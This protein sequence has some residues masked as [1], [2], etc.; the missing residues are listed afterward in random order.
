MVVVRIMIK[1]IEIVNF[2]SHKNTRLEFNEFTNVIIG[3]NDAGK[4]S[5]LRAINWVVNNRPIGIDVDIREGQ[6][7]VQVQLD[8]DHASI[9]RGKGKE[10]HYYK[11]QAGGKEEWFKAFGKAVPEEV[12]KIINFADVNIQAQHDQ[13]FLLSDGSSRAAKYLNRVINLEDIDK[14]LSN[15]NKWKRESAQE[16]RTLANLQ[17]E[18]EKKLKKFEGLEEIAPKLARLEGLSSEIYQLDKK[19]SRL[20]ELISWIKHCQEELAQ[21]KE[22]QEVKARFE[23]LWKLGQEQEK[24]EVDYQKLTSL[25]N[26]IKMGEATLKSTSKMIISLQKEYDELMPEECPL[27]GHSTAKKKK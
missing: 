9:T 26:S 24:C 15:L 1:A 19:M 6:D 16:Q 20:H 11:I 5:I 21:F 10:G 12:Q 7:H 22:L 14:G 2:Q 8:F 4:T 25:V 3:P 17:E 27:C 23:A 18:A 13:P